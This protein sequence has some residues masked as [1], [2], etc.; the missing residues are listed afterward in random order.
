MATSM[1]SYLGSGQL[2]TSG[3]SI[4]PFVGSFYP[5]RCPSAPG[6]ISESKSPQPTYSRAWGPA[7]AWPNGTAAA[8]VLFAVSGCHDQ[9]GRT[10]C[11][12]WL[13][14]VGGGHRSLLRDLRHPVDLIGSGTSPVGDPRP[15]SP[16]RTRPQ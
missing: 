6:T 13:H 7:S 12:D 3:S 10:S 1:S 15:A 9:P 16:A 2:W 8:R 5:G 14:A 4:P 11:R